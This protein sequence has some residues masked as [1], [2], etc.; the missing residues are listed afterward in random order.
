V[1]LD[2]VLPVVDVQWIEAG[3]HDAA[4]A[5]MLSAG[6]RNLSI[7]DCTSFE[8][9]RSLGVKKAFAFDR[10]FKE[11]GFGPAQCSARQ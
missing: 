7:V 3:T 11:Q 1:F 4:V 9:M 10:H 8:L 2:E 6:R 5:A